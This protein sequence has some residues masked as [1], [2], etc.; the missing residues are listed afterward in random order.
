[1]GVLVAG[2][3]VSHT[4]MMIRKFRPEDPIH[5]RVHHAFGRLREEIDRLAPDLMV[6]IGSEHLNSFGY[7]AFPQICVGIGQTCTG[8][9]DGGVAS[10]QVP[11]AGGFAAQLLEDG[12]EAGFDLAFSGN[13]RID[14]AFMAPLSLIR[15]EMDIP[16]VPV[17]QNASTEP[18][19]PLWRSADLGVLIR[20]VVGRRPSAERVVLLGTGGLSHWVATPD[21]GTVNTAFDEGL[22]DAVRAGDL[23]RLVAMKIADVVTAA[24]NGAPEIRN[25]ITVMAAQ[26]G[27]GDVL[28]YASVPDWA[29][30]IALARLFPQDAP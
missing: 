19:P 16:V 27:P 21:M 25:W 24:G 1:M 8:W 29:T 23:D 4:A 22:L 5:Q 6:V 15:P 17:W 2:Y 26:P 20:D 11:L 7:E 30:G 13:P 12:L 10:A 14:H 9:G 18:I 28:A 3:G